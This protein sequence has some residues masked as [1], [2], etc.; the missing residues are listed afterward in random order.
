MAI[1]I[2]SSE[3]ITGNLTLS[4]NQTTGGNLYVTGTS[5]SNVVISRD[6]MYVDAGQLYIGADD[7]TT[8]DT[9]RQRVTSGSYFIES[10]KSG[11]WTNRLQINTA[12]TLIVQQGMAI[13]GN[14][15]G[16]GATFTGTAASGAALVTIE[17]NSGSTATSYGL[18]VKGGG[19][20]SSGKTFEVRDDSGNT[21]LIVKGN[22]YV[23]IGTDLPSAPLTVHGQQKWYTTD[24][25]GN[26]LRGFFNPG[27]SGDPAEF[28]LYQADGTTVGVELQA[29]GNSFFNGG[30]VGIGY[31][32]LYNQ[33]SGGENT[34]AIG[35]ADNA[36]LYLKS[37]ATDG[38][39]HVLF[40][41]TGGSLS[42]YDK[43]RGDYNMIINSVGNIGIGT[44]T[45]N[46]PFASEVAL[47]VGNTSVS[48]NDSLITIA[49]GTTGSGD[50]Y[51]ADGNS[52][53]LQYRGFI[54]YKHN[55]DYLA[56]GTNETTRMIIQANGT[57]YSYNTNNNTWYGNDAGLGLI[58]STG[59][60][61]VM[62]GYKAGESITTGSRNTIIGSGAAKLLAASNSQYS[63]VIG[64]NALTS[65]TNDSNSNVVIGDNALGGSS[66]AAGVVAIGQAAANSL[67]GNAN[68]VIGYGAYYGATNGTSGVIIG[69]QAGNAANAIGLV[70]IGWRAGYV[71]QAN[72]NV[73][74]G[75]EAGRNNTSGSSNVFIGVDAGYAN[76]TGSSNTFVGTQAGTY[77]KGLYNTAL[78]HL[79][80]M[81][82]S[83]TG[84]GQ[85]NTAIG[86][87]AGR[88][89]TNANATTF[90]GR[91]AGY[92]NTTGQYNTGIG[93]ASLKTC[94]IGAA[95]TA[96]GLNALYG[97]T[98]AN[99][100]TS[101]G[102]NAGYNVTTGHNNL[103]L[104]ANAGRST[105]S[106]GL[107]EII[108]GDN[109]IQL[110][111]NTNTSFK[112]KIALTV[113]SDKRDKTNF[114]E[115][116]LGLD[117]VNKLKP[118]S[119]EFK[120]ERESNKADG[121]ERYG[122]FAQDIL[123]LEGEKPV[124]INNDDSENLTYTSDNLIPV[125]VKAIQELKAEIELLKNK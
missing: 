95:N 25:D 104:G 63:V 101:V 14:I 62:L 117:F 70:I 100:N 87:H 96:I 37:D 59:A 32:G 18:L 110:G 69:Y 66:G 54:S 27:G 23:G 28:S 76:V 6:N 53:G 57:I 119:F 22:G 125:L 49:S 83:G 55:G 91:N 48:G 11:T 120:K 13:S 34:L 81:G 97:L 118:T 73:Y 58:T 19:N 64:Y 75:Q 99:N 33:I 26:E 51:F 35:D 77:Q 45:I 1:R 56:F 2:L 67:T 41:G 112:C 16:V 43:T 123:E 40:S 106:G 79:A 89:T 10:R 78:G 50:I 7:S 20:S 71:N 42:F 61:N 90:V 36:S 52:G 72:S 38:H 113:V 92:N 121:I 111:N 80:M 105:A 86:H 88:F 84:T 30:N 124:I 122:F 8:D 4:G 82:A 102:L 109:Q 108:S 65:A 116:P 68:T 21:D 44:T 93:A 15:D 29:S 9:F 60:N 5:N 31:T 46:N 85:Q 17:N 74:I 3:N 24:N 107:G 94:T 115:I 114:K 98:S 103:L 47:Q 12:G 39:N